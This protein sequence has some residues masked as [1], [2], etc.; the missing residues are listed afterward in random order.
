MNQTFQTRGLGSD[1]G[2]AKVSGR[3]GRDH[4]GNHSVMLMIGK[5]VAPGVTGGCR[6]LNA[7]YVASDIDSET[8]ASKASGGDIP[9]ADTHVAAAKTLGVALGLD[10]ATLAP[11]FNDNGSIKY[12]KSAIAS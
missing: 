4:F 12:A 3:S 10:A 9:R 1:A 2:T 7:A 6:P 5:N 8:G 11:D